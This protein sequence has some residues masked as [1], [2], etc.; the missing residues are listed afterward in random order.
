MLYTKQLQPF[1]HAFVTHS[2]KIFNY[3]VALSVAGGLC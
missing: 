1:L 2:L 3:K